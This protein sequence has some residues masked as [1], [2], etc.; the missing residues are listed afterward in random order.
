MAKYIFFFFLRF[1]SQKLITD[2]IKSIPRLPAHKRESEPLIRS[3]YL[4]FIFL[5]LSDRKNSSSFDCIYL[6][7]SVT[8]QVLEYL[9]PRPNSVA[10]AQSVSVID[11]RSPKPTQSNNS[12]YLFLAVGP[13]PNLGYQ[14]ENISIAK[15]KDINKAKGSKTV[16]LHKKKKK[17]KKNNK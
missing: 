12:T 6:Y 13:F 5:Y 11:R 8:L 14:F 16:L 3:I 17:K 9:N 4:L 1:G 7:V 2:S 15:Y 10:V